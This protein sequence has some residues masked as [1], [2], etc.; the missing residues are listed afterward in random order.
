[1]KRWLDIEAGRREKSILGKGGSMSKGPEVGQVEEQTA[2]LWD[3]KSGRLVKSHS[4]LPKARSFHG[5]PG[6]VLARSLSSLTLLEEQSL[7][8]AALVLVVKISD[9]R[10]RWR[11]TVTYWCPWATLS[12]KPPAPLI[13]SLMRLLCCVWWELAV[14]PGFLLNKELCEAKGAPMPPPCDCLGSS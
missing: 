9:F 6:R 8:G 10:R 1:M 4:K 12:P 7:P 3:R 11:V 5:S 13:C 2:A 14:M